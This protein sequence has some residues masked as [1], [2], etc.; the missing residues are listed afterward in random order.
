[1]YKQIASEL[2]RLKNSKKAKDLSWFFK[3]GKGE[4]GEGDKFLGIVV[5]ELRIVAQKYASVATLVD[6]KKLLQNPWHEMRLVG[7]LIL[8]YKYPIA[9]KLEQEKI[10]QFYL[11]NTKYI[12]NWDLVDL[13]A[14]KIT[15]PY[16]FFK[17]DRKILYR[18]AKSKN[19]WERRI[20]VLT[21]FY[22]IK[23]NEFTDSLKL[24]KL[25]LYDTHDLMHKAVGWMLR[26]IG[27]R[28]EQVLNTFLQKYYSEMPRAML[29]YAIER[30]PDNK[31][32]F[33]MK[34]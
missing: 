16:L 3:T 31:K 6:I 20:A 13:S 14:Y 32:K 29:R 4:Y 24:A 27:K 5:P 2:N 28:D 9:N 1:M 34:K 30:L 25:L 12:N 19:I 7:L 21:T 15:G 26:E 11:Q 33:Y 23:Q 8:T 18:L 17:P 22:F 10:Y